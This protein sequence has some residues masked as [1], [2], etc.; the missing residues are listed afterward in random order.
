VTFSGGNYTPGCAAGAQYPVVLTNDPSPH[1]TTSYPFPWTGSSSVSGSTSYYTIY[2]CSGGAL[3]ASSPRR[4]KGR[5]PTG[6][7]PSC[8]R[9][10]LEAL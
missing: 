1:I 9:A 3:A 10:L 5:T 7:G 4:K 2:Q 6:C 8:M